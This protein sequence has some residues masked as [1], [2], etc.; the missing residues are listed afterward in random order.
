MPQSPIREHGRSRGPMTVLMEEE[1]D[2]PVAYQRAC[3][4]SWSYDCFIG[5]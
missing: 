1:E 5:W 4:E 3:Q 2:A